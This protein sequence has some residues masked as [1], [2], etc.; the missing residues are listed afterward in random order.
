MSYE[1]SIAVKNSSADPKVLHLEPWGEQF[2][3]APGSTFQVSTK[4]NQRGTLEVEHLEQEII[5]WA[6]SGSTVRVF[7]GGI[8]INAY[9]RPAVPSVPEGK[10]VSA[11]F[12]TLLGKSNK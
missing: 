1:S 3:M 6:W 12:R 8:E 7:S 9:E 2:V 10:S 5:V 4:A 11:F